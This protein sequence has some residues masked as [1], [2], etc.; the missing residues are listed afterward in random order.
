MASRRWSRSSA[1]SRSRR[2]A[3]RLVDRLLDAGAIHP[4]FRCH[5][6]RGRDRC[7]GDARRRPLTV[8]VPRTRRLPATRSAAAGRSSS[9]T[10]ARTPLSLDGAEVVRLGV[11]RGP[12]AARNAGL[13]HVDTEFVAFVDTDV[14]IRR[15]GPRRV[16]RRTS[17]IR[18]WRWS[19]RG[20]SGPPA[21]ASLERYEATHSPLDL[22]SE[23]ARI[24]PGTRVSFVP[25]AVIVC[26]TAAIRAIGGFDESLRYGEDVDLVWRLGA[27]GWRCRYEPGVVARHRTRSSLVGWIEQRVALRDVGCAA[28]PPPSR[29]TRAG[30]DERMERR[31]VG[32]GRRRRSAR[33]RRR[34]GRHRRSLWFASS[35]RP[36]SREPP[37]RGTRSPL[38]RATARSD[39][40]PGVVA[41]RGGGITRV[42]TRPPPA[43]RRGRAECARRLEVGAATARSRSRT[44]CCGELDDVAY[45]TG[46]WLGAWQRRERGTA[47]ARARRTGRRG[48]RCQRRESASWRARCGRRSSARLA[49]R[50]GDHAPPH[51]V[52]EDDAAEAD[53][54][55]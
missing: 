30:A 49:D 43:R 4:A 13:R 15:G 33:R 36:G 32:S 50:I 37:S 51:Q 47:P 21:A 55:H 2:G 34:G 17:P 53:A 24:A 46:V 10:R 54:E 14:E 8:V 12:A 31:R 48:G 3:T 16:A 7:V 11:N 38:R 52:P 18:R 27:A 39:L 35:R 6:R 5:H 1:A 40:A 44:R 42:A 28:R 45:G 23:P 29:R 22:G 20:S 26:R 25:A 19:P 41:D 9:T